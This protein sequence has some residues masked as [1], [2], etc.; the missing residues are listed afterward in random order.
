DD[1]LSRLS[2]FMLRERL[3][4]VS[5]EIWLD[6]Q[7]DQAS[8]E[9]FVVASSILETL[10]GMANAALHESNATINIIEHIAIIG[11]GKLGGAE[12]SYDSD[13]DTLIVYE[14]PSESLK[15]QIFAAASKI[16]EFILGAG[17]KLRSRGVAVDIDARLRPE[18]RVGALTYTVDE[19]RDYYTTSALTWEKQALVRARYVAGNEA[20][21][22][23]Y[24]EMVHSVIY[25]TPLPDV[26]LQEIRDMKRRMET[27]RLKPEHVEEDLK[28]GQGGMS[29]IEF[30][31]Q[32][33][34]LQYGWRYP[35]LRRPQTVT[36]LRT[37]GSLNLLPPLIATRLAEAYLH[38]MKLRLQMALGKGSA[39]VSD[40]DLETCNLMKEVR[41]IIMREFYGQKY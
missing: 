29:D 11:L 33:R 28:L 40:D 39:F 2:N 1:S 7:A 34:Q 25:A 41:T 14:V 32:M 23:E 37:L 5:R 3:W 15:P 19:F 18:G 36:T 10:L 16:A 4:N 6:L 9:L 27:E 17:P 20:L 22:T 35:E 21:G 31:V 12:L 26:Q 13:W 8:Q 38:F 24:L 30:L